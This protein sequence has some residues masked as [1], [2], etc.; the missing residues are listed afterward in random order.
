MTQEEFDAYR[1]RSISGYAAE[2]VRAGNWSAEEAELR[3]EKETD[4]L[5]PNGVDPP[6]MVLLVGETAGA[7]VGLV[8]I[9]T[10][11]DQRAGTE[12]APVSGQDKF[13]LAAVQEPVVSGTGG[14]VQRPR[15]RRGGS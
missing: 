4:D 6:G 8:W 11:P 13:E 3:A 2:H 14:A 5:L 9:G 1:R 7:V 15:S 12:P 10:A